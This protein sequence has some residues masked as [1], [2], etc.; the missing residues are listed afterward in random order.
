[1]ASSLGAIQS[2]L[3]FERSPFTAPAMNAPDEER[4]ALVDYR[5]RSLVIPPTRADLQDLDSRASSIDS[6]F[7]WGQGSIMDT[8][9]SIM[10]SQMDIL[11]TRADMDTSPSD[12]WRRSLK[13]VSHTSR[14]VQVCR[15]ATCMFPDRHRNYGLLETSHLTSHG[16]T[17]LSRVQTT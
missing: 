12:K 10:D 17:I 15:S 8:S 1:M 6:N 9:M 3:P 4:G 2:G 7:S 5:G 11:S 13:L 14:K 16:S